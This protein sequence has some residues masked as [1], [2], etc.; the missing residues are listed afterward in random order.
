MFTVV[1][2]TLKIHS[3]YH[4]KESFIQNTTVHCTYYKMGTSPIICYYCPEENQAQYCITVEILNPGPVGMFDPS[5]HD[6]LRRYQNTFNIRFDSLSFNEVST[7]LCSDCFLRRFAAQ[8]WER[9]YRR[10]KFE[11]DGN[12]YLL[13]IDYKE[14]GY[15]RSQLP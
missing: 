8:K 6:L 2:Y 1:I 5:I 12:V 7:C 9:S 11:A 15:F 10:Q 3:V 13:T 14:K 4:V